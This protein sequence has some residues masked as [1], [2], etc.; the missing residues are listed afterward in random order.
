MSL[1]LYFILDSL[2]DNTL[3]EMRDGGII[4]TVGAVICALAIYALYTVSILT[5][6]SFCIL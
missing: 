2:V 4:V 5:R 1:R 6:W 3:G